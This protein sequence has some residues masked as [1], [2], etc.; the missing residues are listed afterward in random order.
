MQDRVSCEIQEAKI[1]AELDRLGIDHSHAV[2]IRDE[3]QKG[4]RDDRPGFV[5]TLQMLED[6]LISVLSALAHSASHTL[7]SVAPGTRCH[8]LVASKT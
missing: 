3:A 7:Q 8:T 4:G 6:G 1:R 2:V 5:K